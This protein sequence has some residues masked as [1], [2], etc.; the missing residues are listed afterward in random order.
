VLGF[1][2]VFRKDVC[3]FLRG[4]LVENFLTAVVVLNT[5]LLSL[6]GSFEDPESLDILDQLNAFCTWTFIIEMSLKVLAFGPVGYLRDKMN[7]FDGSIVTLSILEMTLFTGKGGKAVSAFRAVRIFRTFR[8]LRV[9]RLLRS[10]AFM[11]V[12]IQVISTTM[13]KFMYICILMFL[14]VIIYALLGMQLY[15]GKFDLYN[16]TIRSTFDS[17][18]YSFLTVF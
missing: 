4:K 15:V 2:E 17:F 7:I 1:A 3:N 9:T 5:I 8:V 18:F 6:A 16:N 14:F 10:L 12:I 11:Q 13:E